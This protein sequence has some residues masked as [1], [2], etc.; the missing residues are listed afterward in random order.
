MKLLLSLVFLMIP[1]LVLSAQLD[2]KPGLWEIEM[3]I[4]MNGKKVDPMAEMRKAMEKMPKAQQEMMMKQMGK[5]KQNFTEI[6]YTKEMLNAPEKF[7]ADEDDKECDYKI[8][9]QT[10]TS[11]DMDF[12][13]KDGSKGTTLVTVNNKNSYKMVTKA[14]GPK[15]EKVGMNYSGKFKQA[16]CE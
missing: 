7:R 14:T 9:K 10:A 1:S 15:G 11:L 16:S 4:E 5:V 6:C 13:C 3:V 12:T 8:K 2:M